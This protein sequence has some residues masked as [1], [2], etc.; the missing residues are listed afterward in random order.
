MASKK[1]SALTAAT[2]LAGTEVFPIV[3]TAA[4]VKA[5]FAQALTYMGITLAAKAS[6]TFTGTPAAP[7][8]A[9]GTNTTQLAT[10][11]FVQARNLDPTAPTIL[12]DDFSFASTESGEIGEL[13][14]G[15]TNGTW[16]IVNPEEHHPGT[17]RRTSTAVSGTVA[18][19]FPGGGGTAAAVRMDQVDQMTWIIKP[20]T[21]DVDFDLRFGLAS[22]FTDQTPTNGVY[23][24]KLA[25][26]TNWF[27]VTRISD[28]ETPR[29]DTGV[30][31]AA[32]WIKLTLRRVDSDTVAFS[33]NGGAEV[34]VSTNVPIA[35]NVLAFG[36]HI[37]P[38]SANARSVDVDFFSF[39]Y[40]AMTR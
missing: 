32:S 13:G 40:A 11:A 31:F 28:V 33:V 14:W 7:T 24:E 9:A 4:T 2:A 16:G 26:D 10:T 17:C 5:T 15:F 12:R 29:T 36:F 6:P 22:D 3:Q 39:R 21:A 8:A 38:Q 30:A 19:S 25:A 27:A 34:E 20:T 1:I 35:S 37:V 23:F 18:S